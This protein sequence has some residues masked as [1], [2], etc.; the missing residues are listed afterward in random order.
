MGLPCAYTIEVRLLEL[1][2]RSGAIHLADIHDHWLFERPHVPRGLLPPSEPAIPVPDPLLLIQNPPVARP[3]GRPAA[4]TVQEPTAA[5]LQYENSTQRDPSQF[6]LVERNIQRQRGGNRGRGAPG[7]ARG[8]ARGRGG[9]MV[10]PVAGP[11][12]D[13]PQPSLQDAPSED[14]G[15]QLQPDLQAEIARNEH[16]G[17]ANPGRSARRARGWVRDIL[18]QTHLLRHKDYDHSALSQAFDGPGS[19]PSTTS[20]S[21]MQ[22]IE[23][24]IMQSLINRDDIDIED[25]DA[26]ILVDWN[27]SDYLNDQ[28]D[29]EDSRQIAHVIALIG[30]DQHIQA[31]TCEAYIK[32][33]WPTRGTLVL[34]V[35]QEALVD[36]RVTLHCKKNIPFIIV[37]FFLPSPNYDE[38]ISQRMN[39]FKML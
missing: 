21:P 18:T 31:T 24:V 14:L 10:G 23:E 2:D 26:V 11:L 20:N 12:V 28:Y 36:S 15:E 25:A 39:L 34:E 7:G 4:S 32:H 8:R 6:E 33:N 1:P 17:R 22:H 5:Q 13:H 37:N 19:E 35:V 3:R 38:G 16:I 9:P 29:N 30:A 27:L